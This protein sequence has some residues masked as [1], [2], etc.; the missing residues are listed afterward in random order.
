MPGLLSGMARLSRRRLDLW[1]GLHR[2]V[3]GRY[4]GINRLYRENSG[5]VAAD[6]CRERRRGRDVFYHSRCDD[7]L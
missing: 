2:V 3:Y 7:N 4:G 6:N 1:R 5:G